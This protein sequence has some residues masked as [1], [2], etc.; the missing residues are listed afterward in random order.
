MDGDY[1]WLSKDILRSQSARHCCTQMRAGYRDKDKGAGRAF[2]RR[3]RR[4]APSVTARIGMYAIMEEVHWVERDLRG[5]VH[6]MRRQQQQTTYNDIDDDKQQTTNNSKQQRQCPTPVL[7]DI[8]DVG[9]QLLELLQTVVHL[10]LP[11]WPDPR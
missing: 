10:E 8:V 2:D 1:G 9:H 4:H 11:P 5:G 6:S 3:S 7:D